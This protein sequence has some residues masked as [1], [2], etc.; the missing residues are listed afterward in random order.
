MYPRWDTYQFNLHLVRYHRDPRH[1]Q[2]R[3]RHVEVPRWLPGCASSASNRG[4]IPL[5]ALLTHNYPP[6][7]GYFGAH[8]A[9]FSPFQHPS[10]ELGR[11]EHTMS[12]T[13]LGA[14]LRL[15]MLRSAWPQE[16]TPA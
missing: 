9:S 5:N 12:P 7:S 16:R 11:P 15:A 14:T 8:A 3:D 10:T 1:E 2:D 6:S 4:I 13:D